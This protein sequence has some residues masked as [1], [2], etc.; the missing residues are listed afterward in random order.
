MKTDGTCLTRHQGR[1]GGGIADLA[2]IQTFLS[3]YAN[4]LDFEDFY[5]ALNDAHVFVHAAV[6][7][8]M[9][10]GNSAEMPEFCIQSNHFLI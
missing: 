1:F 8:D 7:G 2:D 4:S 5:L 10:S 3:D 9:A 6:G